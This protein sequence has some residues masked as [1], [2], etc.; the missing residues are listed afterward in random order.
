M[1]LFVMLCRTLVVTPY[2][3]HFSLQDGMNPLMWASHKGHMECVK[4]L[5]DRDAEFNMQNKVR[6]I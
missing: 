6:E 5:L 3:V 4:L 1:E 2:N